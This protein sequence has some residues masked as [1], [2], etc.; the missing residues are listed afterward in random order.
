MKINEIL[1]Q[2]FKIN[3]LFISKNFFKFK[4]NITIKFDFK[5]I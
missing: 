5:N 1:M 4:I 2:L 3:F